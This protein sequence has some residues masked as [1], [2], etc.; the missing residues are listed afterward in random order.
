MLSKILKVSLLFALVISSFNLNLIEAQTLK[1][2]EKDRENVQERFKLSDEHIN[3]L[4]DEEVLYF[5]NVNLASEVSK[6]EEYYEFITD[7]K[8]KKTTVKKTT[9]EK[10][11]KTKNEEK[12]KNEPLLMSDTVV[13]LATVQEVPL[14]KKN[15]VSA[16]AAGEDSDVDTDSGWLKL[17]TWIWTRTDGTGTVSSRFE[18]TKL[19]FYTDK[20]VFA[21]G[22]GQNMSSIRGSESANYK[23]DYIDHLNDTTGTEMITNLVK[24]RD[25]GGIAYT[26]D[27]A[28]RS[29]SLNGDGFIV[30]TS[31]HRGYMRYDIEKQLPSLTIADAYS[32]YAHQEKSI[33]IS[34]SV[35]IPSGGAISIGQKEDFDIVYGDVQ[36]RNW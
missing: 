24:K 10:Y 20:D 34:P 21:I 22:I 28:D 29:H 25:V 2:S 36:V 15:T 9:K 33:S 4:S 1:V 7:L 13:A 26:I 35:S 14:Q 8:T 12:A 27:L 30:K 16:L 6:K 19:P 5:L 18:W 3:D 23:F 11:E 32:S 31:N 17:E